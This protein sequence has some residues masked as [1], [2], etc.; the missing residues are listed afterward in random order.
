MFCA[1]LTL[2]ALPALRG[3]HLDGGE[4]ILLSGAFLAG[5]LRRFGVLGAGVGSQ[6][7]IGQLTAF[8]ARLTLHDL[9]E[10]GIAL[11]IAVVA[12]VV[13][14]LLSGPAEQPIVAV[15]PLASR[16]GGTLFSSEF[17][18]GLQASAAAAV[19]IL[20]NCLFGL[21]EPVWAITACVYGV[22]ATVRGDRGAIEATYPRHAR[23]CA[24]RIGMSAD[25]GPRATADLDGGGVLPHCLYD[26]TPRSL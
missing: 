5:W 26:G 8:T 10:I 20:L 12:A 24:A 4:W 17:V 16:P 15:A 2:F 19:I 11:A 13:P 23:G 6:I 7:Y 18:M 21:V 1:L 14:R 25:R 3:Y 9:P 22:T